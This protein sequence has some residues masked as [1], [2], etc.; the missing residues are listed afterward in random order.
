MDMGLTGGK[1]LIQW[2]Y[3]AANEN[4]KFYAQKIEGNDELYALVSSDAS[5]RRYAIGHRPH[6]ERH[7]RRILRRYAV[8]LRGYGETRPCRHCGLQLRHR[9]SAVA[10]SRSL[11]RQSYDT[12]SRI[13]ADQYEEGNWGQ[14]WQIAMAPKASAP[15]QV[16]LF[17]MRGGLAIDAALGGKRVP[18]QWTASN[19]ENQLVSIQPVDGL[20]DVYQLVYKQGR[21]KFYLSAQSSGTTT[22]TTSANDRN[23]YFTLTYVENPAMPPRNHWEDETFFEENKEKGHAYYIPYSTT[24]AMLADAA[25]YAK[26]WETPQSDRVMSLNGTWKLNYVS[27]PGSRPGEKAFWGDDADV[28]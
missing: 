5:S 13:F 1:K 18:L 8:S 9:A 14:A 10:Q 24:A 12:D 28:S 25:H 22:M 20:D 2:M 4:Q 7:R 15:S 26:P 23:T 21:T 19:K 27:A 16:I 17:S 6:H 11:N 3:E